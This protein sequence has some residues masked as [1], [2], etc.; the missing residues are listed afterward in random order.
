ML[1]VLCTNTPSSYDCSLMEPFITGAPTGHGTHSPRRGQS[2]KTRSTLLPFSCDWKPGWF[3]N[4]PTHDMRFRPLKVVGTIHFKKWD[5]L[6]FP[7]LAIEQ[8]KTLTSISLA[9]CINNSFHTYHNHCWPSS[10]SEDWHRTG[11]KW[12]HRLSKAGVR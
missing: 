11:C 12:M 10:L 5:Q 4:L 1:T 2:Y 6:G 7:F 9:L 8:L 3:Y